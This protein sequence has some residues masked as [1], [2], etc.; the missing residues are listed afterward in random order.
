MNQNINVNQNI[1]KQEEENI[2]NDLL[3]DLSNKS[4]EELIYINFNQDE[5]INDY[6]SKL[7][8]KNMLLFQEVTDISNETENLKAE[9]EK[10]KS[11][12]LEFRNNYEESENELHELYNQKQIVEG[13]FTVEA[14]IEEMRK[15]IEE[16]FQKPRQKLVSEFNNKQISFEK[17]KEDFKELST[18]Y[19]YHNIIKEKLNL[20]KS[21][22]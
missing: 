4:I 10:V 21:D 2:T 3:K 13:R 15:H 18:K 1:S 9:Y 12:I 19:H 11:E 5:Y 6:T 20:Y 22:I 7:R 17:F 14:L 8:E 16:N